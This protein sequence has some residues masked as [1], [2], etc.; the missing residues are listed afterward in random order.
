MSCNQF[1]TGNLLQVVDTGG[2]GIATTVSNL[3][4]WVENFGGESITY[5]GIQTSGGG[6]TTDYSTVTLSG[7][8]PTG[9]NTTYTRQSTGFVLDTGTVASEIGTLFDT[10]SSYYYYVDSDNTN[11]MLIFSES[12]NSWMGVESPRTDY[13]SLTLD[14]SISDLDGDYTRQSFK[15][16]LILELYHLV[17]HYLMLIQII[18]GF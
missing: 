18:G 11:R 8:T 7:L 9:F 2:V 4:P 5:T 12:D 14:A 10:D 13:S 3:T 16:N 17:M 1:S 15:A 6:T